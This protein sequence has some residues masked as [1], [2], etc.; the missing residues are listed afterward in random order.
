MW[1]NNEKIVAESVGFT[2]NAPKNKKQ[3]EDITAFFKEK[4]SFYFEIGLA[5]FNAKNYK[6]ATLS[7]MAAY[8]MNKY[9]NEDNVEARDNTRLSF[10]RATDT[11]L[12]Q[13]KL[14]EALELGEQVYQ[15][16]PKDIEILI[17]MININ[18]QKKRYSVHR[19]IP[20]RGN[21]HGY[22]K[23]IT[24]CGT[25]HIAHGIKTK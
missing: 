18:L 10:I 9:I 8:L 11:L 24:V 25:W 17:S 5:Q 23:Q 20:Q 12:F 16:M 22:H 7:F 1:S 15:T 6:E 13:K 2:F 19:K 4:T 14:D 3:K 21:L